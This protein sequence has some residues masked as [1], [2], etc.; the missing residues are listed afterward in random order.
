M[1]SD[2]FYAPLWKTPLLSGKTEDREG[3]DMDANYLIEASENEPRRTKPCEPRKAPRGRLR[4]GVTV[5][6][7]ECNNVPRNHIQ[8]NGTFA[9]GVN[10]R[11][12]R[13]KLDRKQ[14]S[15]SAIRAKICSQQPLE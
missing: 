4:K 13:V 8:G 9:E 3:D 14:V 2:R 12:A 11:V 10:I 15:L 1:A 5:P 7:K 6:Y